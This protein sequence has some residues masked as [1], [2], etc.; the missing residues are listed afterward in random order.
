MLQ[1]K[2]EVVPDAP[3]KEDAGSDAGSG[4]NRR[5]RI[6]CPKCGF[7]PHKSDRWSCTCLHSW[8]TFDTGGL[9]P[10]CGKQWTMTACLRCHEWSP[11]KDWYENPPDES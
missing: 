3:V 1:L 9:C 10:G 11:H 7:E 4:K 6:R 2:H 8:N 5:R